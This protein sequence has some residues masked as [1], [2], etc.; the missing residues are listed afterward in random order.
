MNKDPLDTK[1]SEGLAE[2]HKAGAFI[3]EEKA[4]ELA[5]KAQKEAEDNKLQHSKHKNTK[6]EPK[7]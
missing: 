6:E 5:E 3:S 7:G 2:M 4:Q 1:V